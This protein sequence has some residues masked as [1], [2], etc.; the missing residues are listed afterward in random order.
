MDLLIIALAAC[1]ASALA[2]KALIPW[3][4]RR[5][6]VAEEND[7]S[8]H[9]GAI[10]K[11][12]GLPLLLSALATLTALTQPMRLP[13][14]LLAATTLV[15]IVSWRDDLK[16]LPA[17]WRFMLHLVAAALFAASLPGGALV[18]QG[19]LPLV[20]DR[21]L[22]I[23]ALVWMIN[24]FN[25]MD[26][27][28]GIAGTETVA[29]TA[30]YLGLGV[31]ALA[32][33][34]YQPLAAAVL[35]SSLGFLVWNLRDKALVFL[36]D[37]GSAPLGL[38]MGALMIDLAAHGAW[39]AAL[40]LPAYFLADATLTLLGRL[41]SGHMP[42]TAHKTHFY[43]RAAAAYK[44]HVAVVWRVS[45]ANA[46]LIAAALWSG[47]APWTGLVFAAVVVAGLL[48]ILN[49]AGQS[50]SSDNDQKLP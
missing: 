36:G 45:V 26:G 48:A 33:L 39:A 10:P 9:L 29:I 13:L 24:L 35:G 14:A 6:I 38:L 18:F 21:A 28:N 49:S 16:P 46:L 20:I 50:R 47:S 41:A 2:T 7:R 44:S 17:S 30:G 43:Q 22:T 11:G 12:G 32:S 40:I 5:G 25:F 3:L 31:T 19:Y 8:M 15:A 4:A 1:L 42:W 37:V 27:I 34:S 23:V